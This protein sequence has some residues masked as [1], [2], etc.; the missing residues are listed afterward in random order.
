I[1]D[2]RVVGRVDVDV[3]EGQPPLVDLEVDFVDL[4]RRF[5]DDLFEEES[6]GN[7]GKYTGKLRFKAPWYG[8]KKA[9]MAEATGS[10]SGVGRSGTLIGRLGLATKIVTVLRST[11]A[12]RGKLPA[13]QDQGLV[14]D[15]VRADLVM[16]QAG[17]VEVRKFDLDSTSYA[18]SAAG[19]VNFA[20]D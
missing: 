3:R 13:F 7:P 17:R 2:G 20:D 14:Y 10:L 5:V 15:T 19:E 6:R 9:T 8:D 1:E 18:I 12:L 4:T 16:E 11:E